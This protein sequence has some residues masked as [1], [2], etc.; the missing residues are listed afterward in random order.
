MTGEPRI[1]ARPEQ[2]YV[3]VRRELERYLTNPAEEPD[4]SKRETEPAYLTR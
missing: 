2:P 4:S 3:A 1:E